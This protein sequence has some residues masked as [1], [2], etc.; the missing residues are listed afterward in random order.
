MLR[1]IVCVGIIFDDN[2][3]FG[4]I[5]KKCFKVEGVGRGGRGVD[6]VLIEVEVAVMI[7]LVLLESNEVWELF[8]LW[9][10]LEIDRSLVM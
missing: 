5:C 2:L 3:R 8:V 7:V 6:I 10:V 1:C 4:V 9:L